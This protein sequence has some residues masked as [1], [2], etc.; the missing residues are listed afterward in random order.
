MH[1]FFPKL[2]FGKEKK[3]SPKLSPNEKKNIGT[4]DESTGYTPQSA[5][6]KR[7]IYPLS[8][9]KG[10]GRKTKRRKSRRRM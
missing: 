10:G 7:Y 9:R 2:L 4:L 5:V 3:F 8:Y 1:K 6:Y